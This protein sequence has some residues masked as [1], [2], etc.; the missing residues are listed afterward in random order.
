[1]VAGTFKQQHVLRYLSWGVVD[2][3][4]VDIWSSDYTQGILQP[5]EEKMESKAHEHGTKHD[6]KEHLGLGEMTR[7]FNMYDHP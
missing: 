6:R 3:H 2:M 5:D 4:C 1:M 7:M